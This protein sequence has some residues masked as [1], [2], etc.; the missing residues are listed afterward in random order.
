MGTRVYRSTQSAP[1]SSVTGTD[2]IENRRTATLGPDACHRYF[3][4]QC[5]L[6]AVAFL[7][8]TTL[9]DRIIR[10][11]LDWGYHPS[12]RYGR[13]ESGG[14]VRDEKRTDFDAGRGGY[15]RAAMYQSVPEPTAEAPQAADP[16]TWRRRGAARGGDELAAA[17]YLSLTH[18]SI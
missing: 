17:A 7:H 16:G 18:G 10:V 4:H 3:S 8:G 11:E 14:Q 6:D 1:R 2:Q 5:A 15:G 12:R 9:D 13:G